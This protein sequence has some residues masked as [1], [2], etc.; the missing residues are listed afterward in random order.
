MQTYAEL[1]AGTKIALVVNHTS[2]LVNGAHLVDTLLSTGRFRIAAILTPEH[3]FRGGA[4][5]GEVVSDGEYRSVPVYSLYGAT[6]KPTSEMLAGVDAIV[7]DLQDAGVRFFTY[8]STM[9]YCME[10][11]AERRIQFIVLDRPDPL[12]GVTV[13]G[14]VRDQALNSFVGL[15]PIPVRYGLTPGELACMIKGEGWMSGARALALRVVSMKNWRRSMWYDQTGLEW[16]APSPNLKDPETGLLYVGTCLF[17]G[18]NVAEGRGTSMPFKI[19][20]APFIQPEALK[21]LLD[22]YAVPGV[23]YVPVM[24]EGRTSATSGVV[25]CS[26]KPLR[27][28]RFSVKDRD[29]F[30][31]FRFGLAMLFA[32]RSL[33]GESLRTTRHLDLLIGRAGFGGFRGG[34]R[35]WANLY[36]EWELSTESFL[37]LR[38]KYLLYQ[39]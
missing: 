3:G 1:P 31:A 16:V 10:A 7:Y 6:K 34:I 37:K 21:V 14:P 12:N 27:G 17:E 23:A 11:A 4:A 35:A 26:G 5:P 9:M 13:E 24:F 15:L 30:S 33:T 39:I 8:I 32:I 38:Q 36:S 22:R 29:A 20:G 18:T 25:K 19:I 28:L 2:R